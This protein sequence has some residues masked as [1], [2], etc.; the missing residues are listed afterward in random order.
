MV[1]NEL[2]RCPVCDCPISSVLSKNLVLAAPK[3]LE[4]LKRIEIEIGEGG[5][6]SAYRAID[7]LSV[8]TVSQMQKLIAEASGG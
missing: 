4:M 1:T 6:K 8:K 3:L 5:R 7:L 2:E